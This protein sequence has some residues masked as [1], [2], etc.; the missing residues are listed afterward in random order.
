[1]KTAWTL[2]AAAMVGLAT[3]CVAAQSGGQGDGPEVREVGFDE[4]YEP[5]PM[6]DR[7]VLTWTGDPKTTQAVTWRTSPEVATGIAE[8]AEATHGPEFTRSTERYTA[9][10]ES[11]ASDLSVAHYHTVNFEGLTPGTAY[12]YRVG[13]GVNWSEWFQFTTE[14]ASDEP[15]SFVYFGDAQNDVRSMWSRITRE[16]F[17][18]APRAAFF[19]HAGDL[20]NKP[21]KDGEWGEWFEAGSF[22]NATIPVIATPGN[23][24]MARTKL[25]NGSYHYELDGHYPIQFAFPEN[26][27]AG[28]LSTVWYVDY[29]DLRI[30]SLNSNERLDEQT[31]W[32]D[33][34]LSENDRNWT[35][36]TF[37]HPV[38]AMA[39]ERD[40]KELRELWKPILDKHR[41][42]IVLN[43]HDHSYGRTGLVG[44]L[45][46]L[47]DVLNVA[48]G[49]SA[50]SDAGTVYVV[51]V[52]GPKMYDG[53]SDHLVDVVSQ[54]EDTQLYQVLTIDGDEL[55]YVARTALGQVYDAFTLRKT[56]N[57]PNELVEGEIEVEARRR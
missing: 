25:D 41:V 20:I 47:A 8:I 4:R 35:A 10:T 15:F 1:M 19:L 6:P 18:D 50:V 26:G 11:Y 21:T 57:G 55:R 39:K 54:A 45:G 53:R 9:A 51:S 44:A 2:M 48:E 24:E 16:A 40:N 29:G 46:G 7:I 27:P 56:E 5:T 12:V 52:S 32:L 42:D 23:H 28:L 37:H 38:F 49:R 14:P 34:V 36:V 33:R 13:D 31:D 17:R 43:G 3:G 22:I 30:V